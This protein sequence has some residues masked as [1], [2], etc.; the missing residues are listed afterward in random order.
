M[1][2]TTVTKTVQ[3]EKHVS[4]VMVI[5]QIDIMIIWLH[6]YSGFSNE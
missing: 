6:A 1:H 4:H 5:F 2:D 3:L